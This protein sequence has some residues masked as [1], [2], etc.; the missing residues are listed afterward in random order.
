MK[1]RICIKVGSWFAGSLLLAGLLVDCGKKA[2]PLPPIVLVPALVRDLTVR[3]EGTHYRLFFSEPTANSDGSR[4]VDLQRVDIYRIVEDT[5]PAPPQ[6]QPA[7]PQTQPTAPQSQQA[8][9]QTPPSAPGQPAVPGT[10]PPPP[11]TP[12]PVSLVP[13]PIPEVAVEDFASRAALIGSIDVQKIADF[14]QD[15]FLVYFDDLANFQPPRC[16]H[17][18]IT[19]AVQP[20]NRKNHGPGFSNRVTLDFV[21]VGDPPKE[22]KATVQEIGIVLTWTPPLTNI[23]GTTQPTPIGYNI[24]RK[25]AD[26]NYYPL[27]PINPAPVPP[28]YYVDAGVP[29]DVKYEYMIKGTSTATRPYQETARS[30]DADIQPKDVFPPKPPQDLVAVASKSGINLLWSANQEKDFSGYKVYRRTGNEKLTLITQT[31]VLKNTF[32]D[33]TVRPKTTYY[34]VVTAIDRSTPPNESAYSNEAKEYVP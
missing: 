2:D 33:T 5:P 12:P 27:D 22:L 7:A 9:P 6:S 30:N 19:Y 8:A 23:D 26:D 17:K 16:F 11:A 18:R 32:M 20:A 13:V 21:A 25:K 14:R 31:L 10:P 4:L 28:P 34:Y 3:Q 24:Y 29:F 15:A 1:M